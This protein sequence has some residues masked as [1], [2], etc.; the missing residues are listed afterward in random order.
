MTLKHD[1][2]E[3]T[4]QNFFCPA[5]AP[6]KEKFYK[7]INK[8]KLSKALHIFRFTSERCT[9][10]IRRKYKFPG[11]YGRKKGGG[12]EEEGVE[13]V[14]ERGRER[15]REGERGQTQKSAQW[16]E[17]YCDFHTEITN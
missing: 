17:K 13:R 8:L 14:K 10:K 9:R 15:E 2:E 1:L 5:P 12:K 7:H 16:M 6:F 3:Y 11:I 4:E